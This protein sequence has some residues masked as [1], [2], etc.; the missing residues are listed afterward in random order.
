VEINKI[1]Y[2]RACRTLISRAR[3]RVVGGTVAL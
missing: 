1:N 2:E 3:F